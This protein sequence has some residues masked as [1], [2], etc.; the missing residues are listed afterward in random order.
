MSQPDHNLF[1]G[2]HIRL[3]A[4]EADDWQAYHSWNADTEMA[5]MLSFIPPPQ[6]PQAAR[7]WAEDEAARPAAGDNMRYVIVDGNEDIVG[8]L[9]INA[10]DRRAGVFSY[11]IGIRRDARRNGYAREAV[12]L[13]LRYYFDELAYQKA[14][15]QI[16][17]DNTAS[18]RLHESLGFVL[19]GRLRRHGFTRGAHHDML[20]YG[21]LAEEW[22]AARQ[23][24]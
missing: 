15:V 7:R 19:E 8:D 23:P 22:R 16:A 24:R 21:L 4:F 18:I 1:H 17:D 2:A 13:A 3:R 9:T 14:A 5:R 11:G 6:S 20:V 10:C 12:N